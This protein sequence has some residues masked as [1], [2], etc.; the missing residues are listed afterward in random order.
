MTPF[1]RPR[2]LTQPR[3]RV[4]GFHHAGGSAAVYHQMNRWFPADWELLLLDLPG[5]GKRHSQEPLE[6]IGEVVARAVSDLEPWLD[7]VPLALFGHSFGALVAVEAGRILQSRGHPPL[8]VGVSG[9][10]PPGFRQTTRLSELNDED[11][12]RQMIA[13][14]GMPERINAVPEFVTRFLRISRCDLRATESHEPAPDRAPLECP[15]TVF[16]GTDDPWAPPS[17]MAGWSGETRRQ[18]RQRTFPGGHFYFLGSAFDG[19]TRA[20]VREIQAV[21]AMAEG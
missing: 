8:W 16:C 2:P 1:V 10:V 7:G 6:T 15:L 4:F 13:M 17:A 18:F 5:R 9:R 11:L 19:F 20:V 3:M 21:A 14:G 12:L